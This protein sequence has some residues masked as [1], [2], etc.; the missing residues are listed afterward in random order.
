LSEQLNLS[1]QALSGYPEQTRTGRAHRE[2]IREHLGYREF[3][4]VREEK[5][6]RP[7]ISTL[8]R[9][10]TQV[11]EQA[12]DRIQNAIGAQ[13]NE[14]QRQALD[15]LLPV[16]SSQTV[17]RLQWLK[18]SPP[19]ATAKNLLEWLEKIEVCRSLGADRLD[20][21]SL[22]P[23][24]V[25][26]LARRAR[27]RS[28]L[29]IARA[30]A[31]ERY[32]LLACFLHESLRDLT[33]QAIEMHAQLVGR[34][35]RRAEGRRDKE[36]AKKGKRINEKV[37]LLERIGSVILN[38]KVTDAEVR[39]V[40]YQ[41]IPRERLA[42]AVA[43][44][45]ELAQPSDYNSLAYAA[46]SF[47]YLRQF[48]PRFLDVMRF[49]FDQESSPLLEA[50]AFMRQFNSERRR[51]L[52]DAPT[53]FI[54]WRWRKHV[55]SQ[56]Q[57]INRALYEFCLSECLVESVNNGQ[58]WA[59]CSREH[60]SFRHDW[61]GD[62]EW[63]AARRAFL[64]KHLHLADVERFLT[65]M[66]QMLDERMSE[67]DRQ[68]P[69][70]ED[71]V[72]IVDGGI[73]L[74]RLEAI[75]EPEGTEAIRAAIQRLFPRR[76]LPEL[77]VEVH[78][79][80]GFA[81]HLTSLNPQVREIPNL[82]ARKLA[83]VMALGMNIGLDNMAHAVAGMSYR[84]LAW[85]ADWYVREDTLRQAIVDLVNFL[86]RLPISRC[87]GDGTTSSSDGQ[88]FGVQARTLYARVNPHAPE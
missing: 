46:R 42:Q 30:D 54:P 81:D 82:R 83:V 28:N 51:K 4:H 74:S 12:K 71:Q 22:H 77:L 10:V 44:C 40:V 11:R 62:D 13:L 35:F 33:D 23:N 69:E 45:A 50:V 56:G 38:E 87:W 20:L 47:P 80:T 52:V 53:G 65:R 43:E 63:P 6:V 70:L 37:L 27:R 64:S 36:F 86:T 58:I 88:L 31:R 39:R 8:E 68:W 17:S 9:L 3:G 59:E 15:A 61:I 73:H 26:L 85:V 55:I 34:T 14:L 84:D 66:K 16:P 18:A 1:P 41:Y 72:E 57:V 60:T 29:T 75:A 21:T 2:R 24:R 78:G 7:G 19:N 32:T 48:T 79:W 67:V 49:R 25:K 5:I 76:T